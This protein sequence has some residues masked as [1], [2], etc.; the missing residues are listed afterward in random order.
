MGDACSPLP[1]GREDASPFMGDA[2][3]PLPVGGEDASPFIG[4]ACSPLPVGREDASPFMG[5]ACS[6]LPVGG[7]DA[8]LFMGDACGPL[9]VGGEDASPQTGSLLKPD[10]F[11]C[12]T[13][14]EPTTLP[15]LTQ[16]SASTSSD[17]FVVLLVWGC[18]IE[19]W[20]LRFK[21]G[22]S[23]R[24]LEAQIE[25]LEAQIETIL[26]ES[27]RPSTSLFTIWQTFTIT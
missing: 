17:V 11:R 1:V 26:Y 4:D 8:S 13:K 16:T 9:P 2:C 12:K 15:R 18:P 6:P 3:S 19:A 5:D 23:D 21:A 7:E 25:A 14:S 27:R 20:T 24:R 22:S 10:G